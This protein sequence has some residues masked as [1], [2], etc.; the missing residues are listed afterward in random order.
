[1]SDE[2]GMLENFG[3]RYSNGTPNLDLMLKSWN[4]ETYIS[5]RAIRGS[6]ILNRP[7]MSIC[8]ACQPYVFDK[9]ISNTAFL[10][11]GLVARFVYYFP[12]SNIGFGRYDTEPIPK[13]VSERYCKLIYKLLDR[14]FSYQKN[15]E[16]AVC[17]TTTDSSTQ[18]I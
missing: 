13:N 11:S 7:Y 9:I 12:K 2:A 5:Y 17:H 14:K 18:R 6:I 4:G 16:K 1:M 8:L 3:G 10:G 15:N